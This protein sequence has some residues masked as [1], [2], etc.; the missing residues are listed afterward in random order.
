[1]VSESGTATVPFSSLSR[2]APL[3]SNRSLYKLFS[4]Q[5]LPHAWLDLA[6]QAGY[7]VAASRSW[8][9]Y[10][11]FDPPESFA[12]F[13]LSEGLY[14]SGAWENAASAM[15]MAAI[16]GRNSAILAMQRLRAGAGRSEAGGCLLKMGG[17]GG[18]GVPRATVAAAA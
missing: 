12:P 3:P 13:V 11:K 18:D 4:P 1:M 16:A 14:Y 9:A 6:F 2:L 7:E 5:P 8:A 10:P 15:E 17:A